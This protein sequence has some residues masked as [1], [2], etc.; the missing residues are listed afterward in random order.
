MRGGLFVVH[1]I[2]FGG[3]SYPP[4]YMANIHIRKRAAFRRRVLA[5]L[6]QI[7]NDVGVMP[8]ADC[9][10]LV[11]SVSRVEFGRTVREIFIEVSGRWKLSRD[12]WPEDLYAKYERES[13]ER[14]HEGAFADITDALYF[15]AFMEVIAVE[16]QK[17]LGL[18]FTP[19]IRRMCDLGRG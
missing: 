11:T 6:Q 5:A 10:D 12:Q 3:P 16:L 17:R 2:T 13:Y 15:P 14:G 4:L 8:N 7:L 9:P 1:T 19:V 18:L